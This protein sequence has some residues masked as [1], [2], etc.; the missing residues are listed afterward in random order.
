MITSQAGR[1]TAWVTA[2]KGVAKTD[3]SSN[4]A[5]IVF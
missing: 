2:A 5:G 4:Q 3:L 1:R